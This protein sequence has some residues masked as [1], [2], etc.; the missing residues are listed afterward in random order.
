MVE[1]LAEYAHGSWSGWMEY[2]FSKCEP[3]F[4]SNGYDAL[5]IPNE[6]LE[7][8]ARQMN[9]PYGNLPENEKESDRKEAR[10]ILEITRNGHG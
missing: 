4:D 10:K 2:L 9:T 8:W 1:N 7:R 6:F 3:S 5:I